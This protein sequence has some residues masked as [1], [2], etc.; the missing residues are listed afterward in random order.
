[1]LIDSHAHLDMKDFEPD[2]DQVLDRALKNDVKYIITIGID[3]ESSLHA[4]RLAE[5]YP[6]IFASAGIHPHN[7]DNSGKADLE[8]IA[9]MG[10]EKKVVAVGE[11]GLDFYRNNSSRK[12]QLELFNQQL[13]LA[14]II[15]LPVIIH[16][17]DAHQETIRILSDFSGKVK[18]G[19]IHC[20]SGDLNLAYSFIEMGFHVSI[21]GTVTF[22]NAS[23]IHEV[24]AKIPIERMLLET[25]SP[26][27]S[28]V[29]HR[30]KRNEPC[31]VVHIAKRV[32]E[33]R[34]IH[35]EELAEHTCRNT[36]RLFNMPFPE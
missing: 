11:I 36:C 5:A 20:F 15:D 10:N 12:K 1:M 26:F 25:D 28:P 34:G 23:K 29:P 7:A 24:A 18:K 32:A 33:L 30:G 13:D 9:A 31:F 14:S 4:K 16:N 8:N 27:L 3:T 22:K 17:R 6:F 2:R 35:L 19:V 21:P